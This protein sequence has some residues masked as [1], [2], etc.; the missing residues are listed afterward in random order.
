MR[1]RHRRFVLEYIIDLN[2]CAAA[3][4][5]GYAEG[6]AGARA[7]ELLQRADVQA[8]IR[9]ELEARNARTRVT[10]DRV[11]LEYARIGLIDPSRVAS[12]GP[13][14]VELVP[15][16]R[17]S[18]DERAAVKRVSVGGRK[19]ARAQIF[20]LHDKLK[21]LDALARFTGLARRGKGGRF[22]LPEPE[23]ARPPDEA[24]RAALLAKIERRIEEKAEALAE[25]KLAAKLRERDEG[26]T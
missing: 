18:A 7:W 4:R 24:E 25:A 10:G 26:K 19:G 17:L 22:A 23:E 5:A 6:K 21:A 16:S 11:V 15:S 20:E 14:G 3:K 9:E 13:E 8:A 2:G 12:W 1:E